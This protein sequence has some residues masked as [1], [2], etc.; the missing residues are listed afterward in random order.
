MVSSGGGLVAVRRLN[1]PHGGAS[2]F[3]DP[4]PPR[5]QTDSLR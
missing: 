3:P 4:L 2:L 1:L 5:V